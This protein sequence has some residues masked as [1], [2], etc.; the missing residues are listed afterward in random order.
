MKHSNHA[1]SDLRL[2][3]DMLW[4]LNQMSFRNKNLKNQGRW[5]YKNLSCFTHIPSNFLIT[6][7]KVHFFTSNIPLIWTEIKC[8][9]P[10][11]KI[12]FTLVFKTLLNCYQQGY[13]RVNDVDSMRIR[14][15]VHKKKMRAENTREF[16]EQ[17]KRFKHPF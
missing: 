16:S 13:I 8:F 11:T 5:C 14:E 10:L 3:D 2:R 4:F 1:I 7:T 12:Q 17:H 6:L 9:Q 15:Y